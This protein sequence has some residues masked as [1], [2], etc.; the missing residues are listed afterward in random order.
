M[1]ET[2]VVCIILQ[3]TSWF[4]RTWHAL[5]LQRRYYSDSPVECIAITNLLL[6][7]MTKALLKIT[8]FYWNVDL[9]YSFFD[10]LIIDYASY[11][12]FLLIKFS[13]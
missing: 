2:S 7:E 11:I 6:I 8:C 5:C 3:Q 13:S 9:L 1:L 12:L 4:F 10:V